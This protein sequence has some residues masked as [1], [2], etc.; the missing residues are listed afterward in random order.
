MYK[1]ANRL[2]QLLSV[3][4][5]M[6]AVTNVEL[7]EADDFKVIVEGN[8][9]ISDQTILEICGIRVTQILTDREI[10]R[11]LKKLDSSGLFS[12]LEIKK[13]GDKVTVLVEEN[14]QLSSV[15]FE[16]NKFV[17]DEV[18]LEVVESRPRGPFRH[19][20]VEEDI[21][22]IVNL[23]R[24][25]GRYKASVETVY[26]KDTSNMV[27]LIFEINEGEFLKIDQIKFVGNFFFSDK[28]LKSIIPSSQKSWFSFITESDNYKDTLQRRDQKSLEDFY[29][30]NGFADAKITSSVANL[31]RDLSAVKVIYTVV[32]GPQYLIKDIEAVSEVSG[33]GND[34][35]AEAVDIESGDVF[36]KKKLAEVLKRIEN[37]GISKGIPFVK[38]NAN[39]IKNPDESNVIIKITL[40]SGQKLFVERID[41]RGNQQTLDRVIRREFSL[42]EG[43][44]FNPLKLRKTEEKLRALGFFES[45]NLSVKQGSSP[46]KAVIIANVEETSTGSLNFGVGYS[47]D[48][49]FTGS[50]SLSEKNFLGKGQRLNLQLLTSSNANSLS[51]G[52]KEPAFLN[53]NLSAGINLDFVTQDPTEST[54]TANSISASPSVGFQLA[55]D[56]RVTVAYKIESTEINAENS[57]SL[58]LRNDNGRYLNSS[59]SA[60]FI[61]DQRNSIIEPTDGYIFRVNSTISGVGGDVGYLKNSFKSKFYKGVFND[62]IILSAELEAGLLDMLK[63][64]SR[65]TDRFKLG[66]RNLRGFQ[67]GEVGPRDLSGDSLGGDK[68]F[69]TRLETNFPLGLPEEL[70]LYGGVF[71]EF[72]SLWSLQTEESVADSVQNSEFYLRSSLG[73][74]LYWSTPIGPLQFNW[75]KPQRYLENSDKIETFSLNLATRF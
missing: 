25:R 61:F 45:V 44:Y 71:S 6:I 5:V 66:G 3:F 47:T 60:R 49:N 28:K 22:S 9:R 38:A 34:I 65:I 14:V 42:E 27:K 2:A 58:V 54:Y 32:E 62:S 46:R 8:S 67:F 10:S 75:S 72:G 56:T 20:L 7:V 52:F 68:Y 36:N 69:I 26:V 50:L 30:L 73:F 15:S 59:L 1:T 39:L 35:I 37:L 13:S 63:G 17:T 53:R 43:D 23:Y 51:F 19:Y 18:L 24:S 16:G 48:T 64:Y 21:K 70:G 57:P 41:I 29:F 12:N 11:C 55:P 31:E 40:A 4:L 74:S 33:I